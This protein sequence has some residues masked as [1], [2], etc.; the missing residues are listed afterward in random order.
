MVESFGGKVAGEAGD[1][2]TAITEYDRVLPDMGLMDITM[3]PLEGLRRRR[4]A[5]AEE[6]HRLK[7]E[8]ERTRQ[9]AE[10]G[11]AAAAESRRRK[12]FWVPGKAPPFSGFQN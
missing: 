7:A 1:G 11:L 9:E 10:A 2:R 6:A 8:A 12:A 4:E 5:E 3:P